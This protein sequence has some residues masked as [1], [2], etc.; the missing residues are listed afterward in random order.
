MSAA[1]AADR[2]WQSSPAS[3]PLVPVPSS[4]GSEA[5][6]G[7]P[8]PGRDD[9]PARSAIDQLVDT[10]GPICDSAVD[11]LEVAAALEFE[12]VNDAVARE[13]YGF[14]TV[15]ALAAEAFG[16]TPRRPAEPEP[17]AD[18][19]RSQR[20]NPMLH[21]LLYGLP[22]LFFPATAGLLAGRGVVPVLVVALLLSCALTQGVGYLG[23]GRLASAGPNDARRVLRVAMAFAFAVIVATVAAMVLL[24][25]VRLA[26]LVFGAG[27]AAY[28]CGAAVLVT[29]D[30]GLWLLSALAPGA[31]YSAV[32]LA[33]GRPHGLAPWA[34]AALA[35]APLLA[36]ALAVVRTRLHGPVT[37]P[38]MR[39]AELRGALPAAAFGLVAAGLL[40]YP[41]ASGVSGRGGVNPGA[42]LAS[43]PISLSMGASEWYLLWY[44]RRVQR[45][46]RTTVE[47]VRFRV[48]AR[49]A[50]VAAAL[51]YG[52]I[53]M[54]LMVLAAVVAATTGTVHPRRSVVLELVAYLVL[55]TALF[56]ALALQAL[57]L[58]AVLLVGC[59]AALAF[60]IAFRHLGVVSHLTA[61][62]GLLVLLGS[63]GAAQL[64]KAVRHGF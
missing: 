3:L 55:G 25:G 19:W 18:P 46:L 36:V 8:V 29:L 54:A 14:A 27:E 33:L 2:L 17:P 60:E 16:R 30:K 40:V 57:G 7:L 35:T 50:L 34:W 45:L 51:G 22:S 15:F 38:L 44:R 11:P 64:G 28:M 63:Y 31:L 12:G 58:R 32:F 41:V 59:A 24:G 9:G 6:V 21:G 42:L 10:L 37:A 39:P 53:A 62:A 47:L 52:G 61:S 49:R 1:G 56:F 13:R 43:L 4:N 26:A 20:F 48:R 5:L 23:Y